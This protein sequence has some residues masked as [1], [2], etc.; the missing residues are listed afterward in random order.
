[1]LLTFKDALY[2][3]PTLVSSIGL[4]HSS[5]RTARGLNLGIDAMTKKAPNVFELQTT[6][7]FHSHK[8]TRLLSARKSFYL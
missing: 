8:G 5:P 4:V 7:N 1:M 2:R 6:S 3:R